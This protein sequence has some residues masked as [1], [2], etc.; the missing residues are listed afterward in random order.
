M[1]RLK[2]RIEIVSRTVAMAGVEKTGGTVNELDC[3][4]ALEDRRAFLDGGKLRQ[5]CRAC[6][7]GMK[8]NDS[9]AGW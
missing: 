9:T 5:E 8:M 3:S 7:D 6:L 1:G 4:G 2:D